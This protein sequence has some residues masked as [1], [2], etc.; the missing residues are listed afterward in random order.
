MG[1]SDEIYFR[2]LFSQERRN[3]TLVVYGHGSAEIEQIKNRI[4]D[5]T[6]GLGA[7]EQN[8]KVCFVDSSLSTVTTNTQMIIDSI[9]L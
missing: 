6:H 8:N 4:N 5:Y 9:V 3:K 2:T 7:F 1:N